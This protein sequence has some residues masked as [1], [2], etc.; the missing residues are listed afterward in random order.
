MAEN[1]IKLTIK[2]LTEIDASEDIL[3][4]VFELKEKMGDLVDMLELQISSMW[5][6]TMK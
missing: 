3:K 6:H 4:K 2:S 1:A 5:K